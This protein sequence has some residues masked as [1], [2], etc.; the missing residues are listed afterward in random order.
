MMRIEKYVW[1][2][3]LLGGLMVVSCTEDGM[4][5]DKGEEALTLTVS[6]E[7]VVLNQRL[8][9]QEA[10]SFTWTSGSN[11]GTNASILYVL[12]MDVKGN[13]FAG[14]LT[15]EIGA[16]DSR[17]LS[18]TH[19]EL[20][21]LIGTYWNLPL[22]TAAEFEARLTAVVSGH[23]ELIQ[24]SAVVAFKLTS[25]KERYLDLWMVGD[26]TPNGWDLQYATAMTALTDE[27]GGF[28]W[29]GVLLAGEFKFMPQREDWIP[30]FNKD[31]S[32]ENKLIYRTSEDV[33]DEKFV[34]SRTS[35]YRVKVN[36]ETLDIEITDLG[37]DFPA[38]SGQ[39]WMMGEAA[40][41][42]WSWDAVVELTRSTDNEDLFVYNGPL[43]VG[44]IK[45]PM[46]MKTDFSGKFIV[47]DVDNRGVTDSYT[48]PYYI[49]PTEAEDNKWYIN[50]AA[51]YEIV[52]DTENHTIT[53]T[54]Q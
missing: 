1:L 8:A 34:I 52:I 33:A 38:Y 49:Y 47:A 30:S 32:Q 27:V 2:F 46:E 42:G 37:G 16:T 13:D 48:G 19:Y 15:Q 53:F 10:F 21:E 22:E 7:E 41:G 11:K 14:G 51:D 36:I 31:S 9:D 35:N 26:A 4:E 39:I 43:K 45:F 44:Q 40:P 6:A 17:I 23:P 20:N 54:K 3:A 25:Y 12:D 18:F 28:E 50:E 5:T 29:E 24:E